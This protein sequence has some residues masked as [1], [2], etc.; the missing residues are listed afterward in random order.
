HIVPLAEEALAII[1]SIKP[2]EDRDLVFGRRE[3]SFSGWG[4]A[5]VELD[6]RIATARRA[7]GIKKPMPPWLLHDLRRSFVTYMNERKLALPHVIEAIVNHVSGHLAGVAGIYNKAQY[8]DERRRAL[9][10][11]GKYVMALVAG[12]Q[13]N[14]I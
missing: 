12:R 5:K 2:R 4:K 14:V 11:W 7:A 8:L 6:A 13:N 10:L 9:E 1:A 3:G